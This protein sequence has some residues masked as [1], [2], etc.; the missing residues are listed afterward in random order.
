MPKKLPIVLLLFAGGALTAGCSKNSGSTAA[1]VDF[2]T[3]ATQQNYAV[4]ATNATIVNNL[5]LL[6]IA[7]TSTSGANG[8]IIID[9]AKSQSFATGDVFSNAYVG[10]TLTVQAQV[11][12]VP[13][14]T[15]S[16]EYVSLPLQDSISRVVVQLTSVTSN[17]IQ[18]TFTATLVSRGDT[19]KVAST[20]TGGTFYTPF[21]PPQ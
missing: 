7:A 15:Q 21:T 20:I 17:T 2:V 16:V 4:T 18:G 14:M 19:T 5:Y 13:D 1:Y 9:L 10:G 3:G 12:Y 11:E 8:N 6:T